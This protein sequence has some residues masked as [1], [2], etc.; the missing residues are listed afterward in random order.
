MLELALQAAFGNV[1]NERLPALQT[2]T[3]LYDNSALWGNRARFCIGRYAPEKWLCDR[4][5]IRNV[6]YYASAGEAISA[7]DVAVLRGALLTEVVISCPG[8]FTPRYFYD[9]KMPIPRLIMSCRPEPYLD[10][11]GLVYGVMPTLRGLVLAEATDLSGLRFLRRSGL[12]ALALVH[13]DNLKTLD[14]VGELPIVSLS[15]N[16][17]NLINLEGLR[18]MK[19]TR[20]S[21]DDSSDTFMETVASLAATLT[22]LDL[23]WSPITDAGLKLLGQSGMRLRT[24]S[25]MCCAQVLPASSSGKI[26]GAGL[27]NLADMPLETLDLRGNR[28]K[29]WDC[30]PRLHH[31]IRI[32]I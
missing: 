17:P 2:C 28:I 20:L 14:G 6:K 9:N 21:H 19:L 27:S 16:C 31:C 18:G 12:R 26:T 11:L 15:L 10:N 4:K 7:Q 22:H 13:S 23:A 5:S 30:P 25:L 29:L 24:L 3:A 1:A 8:D 32:G